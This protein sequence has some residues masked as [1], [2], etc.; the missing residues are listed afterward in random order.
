MINYPLWPK[1]LP[2]NMD[3]SNVIVANLQSL[4]FPWASSITVTPKTGEKVVYLAKSSNDAR[5]ETDNFV[6]DPQVAGK[7][8]GQSGQYTFAVY[9]SGKLT[10]AFGTGSTDQARIAVVGDSDFA[11]DMFTGDGSDNLLFFQNLVD[12]LSLDSDLINIRA[13]TATE[14]PITL[15]TTVAKET[16]RYLNI[17]GVTA[18]VL[19]FGIARYFLR[20]R[21]KKAD[22]KEQGA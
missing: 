4:I 6:L 19:V 14:R 15:P 11:T 12:G 21:N 16:M 5:E 7:T 2:N 22:N 1:I 9:V 10:S 3:K 18:I 20:R 17:F 8:S 13:K